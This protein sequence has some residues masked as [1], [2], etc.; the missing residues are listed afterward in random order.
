MEKRY[1]NLLI[2]E[3]YIEVQ[4]VWWIWAT[5]AIFNTKQNISQTKAGWLILV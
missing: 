5:R 3:G 2:Y 4:F 1:F